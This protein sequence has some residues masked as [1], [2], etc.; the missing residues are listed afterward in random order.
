MLFNEVFAAS[1]KFDG[2]LP[3]Q[4]TAI[5]KE[6]DTLYIFLV[7]LSAIFFVGIVA[8]MVLFVHKYR[9]SRHKVAA[10]IHGHTWLEIVW[11]AIPTVLVLGI[12]VWGWVIY[13][14]MV[15]PPANA[16]EIRVIGKQWLWQFQYDD[17]RMTTGKLYVPVHTPVKLVMTSDDVLHSFFIPAFRV[18]QD[19]VPGMYT[20]VWFEASVEGEHDIF[21]A[22]YCGAAHSGMLGKVIVLSAENWEKWKRG[23]DVD[24][25]LAHESDTGAGANGSLITQGAKLA[26]VKGCVACHT[27]DGVHGIGPSYKGLYGAVRTFMDGSSTRADD[28]YIRESIENPQAKVVKGF[29]PVMPT[30]KGLVSENEMNALIA[31][32]KSRKG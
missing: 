11:T 31:Y 14:R 6:W 2:T 3:I 27:G 17:G 24:K 8:A 9:S 22:E 23:K 30:F 20:S 26:A 18:K 12:F 10:D 25:L 5:A 29:N 19:T 16:Y 7:I 21:C 4:G 32:I 13:R 1:S 15:T 28:N